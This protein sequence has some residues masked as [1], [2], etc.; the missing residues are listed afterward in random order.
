LKEEPKLNIK[1]GKRKRQT[2]SFRFT[3][4]QLEKNNRHLDRKPIKL[5]VKKGREGHRFGG[6]S[7]GNLGGKK[8]VKQLNRFETTR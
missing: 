7:S 1:T 3:Q 6:K 8:K 4:G 5:Q 2:I